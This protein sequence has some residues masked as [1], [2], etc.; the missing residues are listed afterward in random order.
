MLKVLMSSLGGISRIEWGM[1]R[2]NVQ[3]TEQTRSKVSGSL[4]GSARE[5]WWPYKKGID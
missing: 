3:E 5:V 2:T 1:G 4:V